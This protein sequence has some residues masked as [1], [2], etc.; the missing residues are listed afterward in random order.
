MNPVKVY[1]LAD[2]A[3]RGGPVPRRLQYLHVLALAQMGDPDRAEKLYESYDLAEWRDEDAMALRGRLYKDQGLA[4]P[5]RDQARHFRSASAAYLKAYALNKGYFPAINAAT[6]LWAAGEADQ[7]GALA[8]DV[9]ADPAIVAPQSFYAAATRAEALLLLRRTRE[10]KDAVLDA[11]QGQ[12]VAVGER[13][14]AYRQLSWLTRRGDLKDDHVK[15]LLTT[16]RPPPVLTYTGHMFSGGDVDEADLA[17][18]ITAELDRSGAAI[19]YGALACGSDIV[20]A[21]QILARGGE[22]HVV[23]PF[24]EEDFVRMS[25]RPGGEAWVERFK[26][27]LGSASSV[28]FATSMGHIGRDEQFAYGSQLMMGLARLRAVQLSAESLQFAV[29]DGKPPS[30]VAGA[31]ADVKLW[32]AQGFKTQIFNVPGLIRRSVVTPK[33][34]AYRGP[35]R[36]TRAVVFADF[37]GFSKLPEEAFPTFWRDVLGRIAIVLNR[38]R[39][40]VCSRNTWGDALFAVIEDAPTAADIALD[41]CQALRSGAGADGPAV[42]MRIGAHFGPLYEERDPVTRQTNFYGSEVNLTARIE[43]KAPV[44][45]VYVTQPFAAILAVA[46]PDRFISHYVGRIELAKAFGEIPLYRLARRER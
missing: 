45:E 22:L 24:H 25:V 6:M 5:S 9:L 12:A 23:L 3:L 34:S 40:A 36:R 17:A 41:I 11:L 19:A 10:A 14:T 33:T 37:A 16:L 15:A 30:G 21:E 29:W 35:V 8:R 46:A 2:E 42:G 20:I 26:S 32:R 7:A 27:C 38:H 31:A 39:K 1:D 43:P 18:M 13:A 28:T 44:G 4:A